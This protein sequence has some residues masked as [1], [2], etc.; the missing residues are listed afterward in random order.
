KAFAGLGEANSAI[1]IPGYT[2]L[3]RAQPVY[4][5]HHL[6]AYVEMLA[7]D[8]ERF[9]E[10]LARVNVCPLGSG[11]LA[12]TTLPLDRAIVAKLLGFIDEQGRPVLTQ[13]SMDAVSDRDFVIEFCSAA[14]LM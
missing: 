12:G 2:H 9:R 10:C 6:L 13:N 7:R 4:F 14:A 5:A 11:A 1:I 3:Q 8:Q